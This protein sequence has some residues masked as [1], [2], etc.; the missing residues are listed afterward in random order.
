MLFLQQSTENVKRSDR[1][2]NQYSVCILFEY[3][4]LPKN[5]KLLASTYSIFGCH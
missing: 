5:I 2:L 3:P 1:Y 4:F